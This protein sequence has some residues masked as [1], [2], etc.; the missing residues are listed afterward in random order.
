MLQP[1]K[2]Y[3]EYLS[4]DE[5]ANCLERV[6]AKISQH[7]VHTP[8]KHLQLYRGMKQDLEEALLARQTTIYDERI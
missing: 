7:T 6:Q 4:T 3:V 8:I 1:V 2:L 5:L